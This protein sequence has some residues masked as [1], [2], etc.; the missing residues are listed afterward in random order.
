MAANNQGGGFNLNEFLSGGLDMLRDPAGLGLGA[1]ALGLPAASV[2]FFT[3]LQL[4]T[5][6]ATRRDIKRATPQL[7]NIPSET[8]FPGTTV[9]I[10]GVG[11]T[12][13]DIVSGTQQAINERMSI[14]EA[15][16]E[17]QQ[18]QLRAISMFN[19][20]TGDALTGLQT[21]DSILAAAG[22]AAHTQLRE[23]LQDVNKLRADTL[24]FMGAGF[25]AFNTMISDIKSGNK[26]VLERIDADIT[27]RGEKLIAGVKARSDAAYNQ[28]VR[29]VDAVS[30]LGPDE[31]AI[32]RSYFDAQAGSDIALGLGEIHSAAAEFKGRVDADLTTSLNSA[33]QTMAY[34]AGQLLATGVQSFAS[35]TQAG[36]ALRQSYM[37]NVRQLSIART[38]LRGTIAEF[39]RLTGGMRFEMATQTTRPV[40]VFSDL[41]F[42]GLDRMSQIIAFNNQVDQQRFINT[43]ASINP[44]AAANMAAA[45]SLSNIKATREA[46]SESGGEGIGSILGGAGGLAGG[47]GQLAEGAGGFSGTFP[48]IA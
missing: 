19:R 28:V 24:A 29:Q 7:G 1:M 18:D 23:G 20:Q 13:M 16:R 10:P 21:A 12:G 9:N 6:M 46:Q 45:S 38:E 35:A 25:R 3:A 40:A 37:D 14:Y 8:G 5:G 30:P 4:L 47:L 41:L 31:R 39:T 48:F 2:P 15:M 11:E 43:I 34:G 26:E 27:S 33:M 36:T 42:D 32:M 22:L 44:A 17:Q